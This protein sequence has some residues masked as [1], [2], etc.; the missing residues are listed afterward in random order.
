MAQHLAHDV[1]AIDDVGVELDADAGAPLGTVLLSLL[2]V[3]RGTWSE[4]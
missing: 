1:L 3:A 2:R 4:V